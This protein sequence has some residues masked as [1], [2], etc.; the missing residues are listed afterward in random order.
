MIS[1]LFQT[2]I[3]PLNKEVKTKPGHT[4]VKAKEETEVKVTGVTS[5]SSS[6][7]PFGAEDNLTSQGGKSDS[8][9]KK[10]SLEGATT[11]ESSSDI[12]PKESNEI[13]ATDSNKV[14]LRRE[15]KHSFLYP[16]EFSGI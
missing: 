8:P 15:I 4:G 12:F 3:P 1:F 2:E 13:D 14:L 6:T 7:D 11:S 5:T 16:M 9:P 10:V